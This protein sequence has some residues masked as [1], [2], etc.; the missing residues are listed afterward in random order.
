MIKIYDNTFYISDIV[1]I[2]EKNELE[3]YSNFEKKIFKIIYDWII[4]KQY[5]IFK[6]SGS[7][8][9][10]KEIKIHR[11]RI[12]ISVKNTKE[13][14]K[15]HNNMNSLLCISVDHIGGFMMLIRALEIGMNIYI[16][17]PTSNPFNNIHDKNMD[18]DFSAFV[19]LQIS[20]AIRENKLYYLGNI[21]KVI[22]GGSSIN[23][24]IEEKLKNLNNQIYSAYGMTE[25]ISHIA[26]RKVGSKYFNTIGDIKVKKDNRNCL[27]INGNITNYNDLI[28]NDIA[29][30]ISDTEFIIKGRIDDIINSG[31]YKI[32][33]ENLE[34]VIEEYFHS[35]NYFNNFFIGKLNDEKFGETCNLFIEDKENKKIINDLLIFLKNRVNKYEIPKNIFFIEKFEYTQSSK[36]DKIATVQN[37]LNTKK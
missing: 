1:E 23:S 6:T 17:E 10:P 32:L 35:I 16:I 25:T 14:L 21:S 19:P 33:I 34:K 26:L 20:Q 24:S 15:L 2:I 31:S 12:L 9:K 11:E 3:K 8:G 28:T 4:G 22:I 7:T 27:V 13:F 30:I 18:F 37:F 36:I 5:F 29:E